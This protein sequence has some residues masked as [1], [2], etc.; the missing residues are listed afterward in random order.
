[1]TA[2]IR[3]G[4]V[5]ISIAVLSLFQTPA[6]EVSVLGEA[7]A[8][9]MFP[10]SA[11]NVRLVLHCDVSPT[12]VEL[13][14]KKLKYVIGNLKQTPRDVIKNSKLHRSNTLVVE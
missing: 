7:V 1:M 12:D 8:A 9:R 14:A 6:E 11:T 2:D 4:P 5:V 3:V 10:M 13:V